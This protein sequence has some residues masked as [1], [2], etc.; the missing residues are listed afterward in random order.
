MIRERSVTEADRTDMTGVRVA[1]PHTPR[2]VRVGLA[3]AA[4]V[5]IWIAAYWELQTAADWLTYDLL[6]LSR[7]TQVGSAVDFFLNDVP[8]IFLLLSGIVTVVA[9]IRSYFPPER[10]RRLLAGKGELGGTALAALLGTV[11]PF[12]SCSAVPMFIGFV[13]SGLPLGV[14][15]GFLIASP[16]V[17]EVALVMLAGLFGIQIA[18]FYVGMGLVVAIVGGTVIGHLHLEDQVE[19]YV[20]RIQLGASSE[21]HP[22]FS[23][24]LRDAIA[25]TRGILRRVF[26]WVLGGIAVGAWIH[27]YAPTAL[28][29][30][31]A[32]RGNP[33]AVPIAVL[34][35]VP[36]YSNAAG[37]I[38]IV[39][40]LIQKGLPMGTTLAFMMAITAISTPEM[41]ILRRVIKWKLI[42]VFIAV[43]TLAIIAMGYVFNAVL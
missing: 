1:V 35:A 31:I 25:Y 12:C 17:N 41:I 18:V 29:V 13:E 11:T 21:E 33:F 4:A 10:V 9:V 2:R 27:G 26:P 15:F 28:V 36:L 39:Q 3:I 30:Q 16:V 6:H 34:L 7:G 38:P 37:T 42:A 32:G 40:A 8:K 43:V 23:Q 20:Y 19:D 22:V 5:A 14:T 24:R